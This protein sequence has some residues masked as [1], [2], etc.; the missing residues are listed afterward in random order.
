MYLPPEFDVKRFQSMQYST[1]IDVSR[2]IST[3]NS[4]VLPSPFCH[5]SECYNARS[6]AEPRS[7]SNAA[8]ERN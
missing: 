4:A 1:S 2:R 5:A 6:P 8:L 7:T 3:P